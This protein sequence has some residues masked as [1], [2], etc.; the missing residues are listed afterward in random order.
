MLAWE[1]KGLAGGSAKQ[2]DNRKCGQ[3]YP[4]NSSAHNSDENFDQLLTFWRNY[5]LENNTGILT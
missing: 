4:A 1:S 5:L 3:A 2:G